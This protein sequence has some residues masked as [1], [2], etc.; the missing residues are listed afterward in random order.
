MS[1]EKLAEA[2]RERVAWWREMAD[3]MSV[4]D[5][6]S[7]THQ[8]K[9]RDCAREVD[10]ILQAHAAE[11]AQPMT[12]RELAK[13]LERG[14]K[15]K[16]V[17]ETTQLQAQSVPGELAEPIEGAFNYEQKLAFTEGWNA[18]REAMLAAAPQQAAEPVRQFR[19]V[20]KGSV[21]TDVKDPE[22]WASV[23]AH[24]KSYET[25]VLYT[26]PQPAQDARLPS[27]G[28]FRLHL[29]ELT[30]AEL[31]AAQA[32][33]RYVLAGER[34]QPSQDAKDAALLEWAARRWR[35]E[36]MDRP[37]VNVH[38][39][40]LDDAWRQVIRH[41]GGDDVVICGPR[42]DDLVA[43]AKESGQ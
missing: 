19:V 7:L 8:L 35:A 18:C 39:R 17:A 41:A 2:L 30:P 20:P 4:G 40:P 26:H 21:W 43:M 27:D 11:A 29:G 5:P 28:D 33:A 37:L 16:L 3:E 23:T 15:W 25:R 13:R 1:N 32:A 42:H 22:I 14:E 6:V 36:V 9:L 38:R 31:R 12:P 34:A 24:P 10:G